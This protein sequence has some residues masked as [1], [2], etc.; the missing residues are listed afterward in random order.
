MQ[1]TDV[2]LKPF[3][4]TKAAENPDMVNALEMTLKSWCDGIERLLDDKSR[5]EGENDGPDTELEYWRGRMAKLNSVI[6][7][8]K[9]REARVVLGVLM[10][11]RSKV[12]KTWKTID[13]RITDEAN[14]A[15]DN[16]KY[17][18]TLEKSLEPM[19]S[20]TPLNVI[21]AMPSL[22]NNV[23]MMHTIARYYNTPERMTTLLCKITNQLIANCKRFIERPGK[24]WEQDL[25]ELLRNLAITLRW[26]IDCMARPPITC[27]P[28]MTPAFAPLW[29][30]GLCSEP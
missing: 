21:D 23:K 19:Y 27:A 6:E 22:M 24:M 15:K 13:M 9:K 25:G 5:V 28:T 12:Y 4:F 20:G 18:I 17:L 26:D 7:Q 1:Y 14:E 29:K 30:S 11:A 16:V 2:E 3:A 10:A 8:L